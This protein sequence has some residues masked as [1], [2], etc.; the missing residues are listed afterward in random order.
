[1]SFERNSVSRG[2]R[3]LGADSEHATHSGEAPRPGKAVMHTKDLNYNL[4]F[5]CI[6]AAISFLTTTRHVHHPPE[7]PNV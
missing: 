1:V 5:E 2:A 4:L 3:Q 6:I 7:V